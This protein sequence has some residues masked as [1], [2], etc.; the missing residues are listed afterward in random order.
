VSK[1]HPFQE[2]PPLCDP[3]QPLF[4]ALLAFPT[5]LW[6]KFDIMVQR[7][8]RSSP[9]PLDLAAANALAIAYVA[10]YA[11][12]RGKLIAY[13]RRKLRER[14]IA[15]GSE[16]NPEAI[17]ERLAASG[18]IDDQAFARNRT[19]AL[20]ARGYGER[21]VRVALDQAG[22]DRDT[23]DIVLPVDDDTALAAAETYARRR[24]FGAY[25]QK[26]LD[27]AVKR[28]QLAAMMRAGHTF[29]VAKTVLAGK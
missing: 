19:D 23:T 24:R 7:R 11:T 10:R 16:I 5:R 14:G 15:D 29:S 20:M 18:Y 17:A 12:T 8:P 3:G 28:K 26:P 6:H 2:P 22:I 21:R 1:F 9:R 13:L 27:D 25:S 4:S